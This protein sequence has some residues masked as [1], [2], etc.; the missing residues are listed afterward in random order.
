MVLGVIEVVE[1]FVVVKCCCWVV[2][3]FMHYNVMCVL[4]ELREVNS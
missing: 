2:V 4:R 3:K 1:L